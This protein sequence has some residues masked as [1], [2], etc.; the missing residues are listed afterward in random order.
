MARRAAWV[1]RRCKS[2]TD[3]GLTVW[4]TASTPEGREVVKA[5]GADFV[6]DHSGEN[7]LAE[8]KT[9][10][11]NGAGW[12]IIL[13]MLANVNLG[14]DLPHLTPSGRVVVVGNRGTVEINPRDLMGRDASILG[15][16]LG[17]ASP[18]DMAS[19]H[20]AVQA[21]LKSGALSP[22]VGHTYD[23]ADAQTAHRDIIN[24][25]KGAQ[26]KMVLVPKT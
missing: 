20:A 5:Q 7:Y 24:P 3:L 18:G 1:W 22:I 15:M 10:T 17:N 6:L 11:P 26:G 16:S 4:G 2:R 13:E 14:R 9:Q 25:P 21:G 23:L 12:N 8:G 19:I